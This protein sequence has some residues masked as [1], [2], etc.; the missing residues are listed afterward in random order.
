MSTRVLVVAAAALGVL[1]V[2][3]VAVLVLSPDPNPEVTGPLTPTGASAFADGFLEPGPHAAAYSR[4]GALLALLSDRGVSLA[5]K[6]RQVFVV[7]NTGSDASR[8]V[9]FAWMPGSES[10]MVVEG[11]NEAKKLSVVDLDG[12]AI[13]AV[14]L[15]PAVSVGDGFGLAVDNSNRQAVVVTVTRDTIGGSRH[16]D[17]AVVD[18]QT[19]A[20]RPLTTTPDVEESS[21]SFLDDGNVLYTRGASGVLEAVVM[22]LATGQTRRISPDGTRAIALG[23][24]REGTVAVYQRLGDGP[25]DRGEVVGVPISASGAPGS[26]SNMGTMEAGETVLALHPSGS[27]AVVQPPLGRGDSASRLR[28]VRLLAPP[29]PEGDALRAVTPTFRNPEVP[30]AL[31]PSRRKSWRSTSS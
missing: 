10:I 22:N 31:S 12:Q 23:A 17:L 11:P 19:G 25:E 26:P 8:I 7:R 16:F 13:A 29:V 2:G 1:V 20:V 3:A 18:L 30:W 4:N 21:P 27:E 5:D 28:A 24:V 15:Q 6:G 9:D 14:A